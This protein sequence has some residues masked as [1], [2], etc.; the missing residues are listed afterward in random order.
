[1]RLVIDSNVEAGKGMLRVLAGKFGKRIRTVIIAAGTA[2]TS[3]QPHAV[4]NSF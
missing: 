3:K 1:M 2:G 4:P